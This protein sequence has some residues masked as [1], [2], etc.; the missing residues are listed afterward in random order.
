M[1]HQDDSGISPSDSSSQYIILTTRIGLY[2]ISHQSLMAAYNAELMTSYTYKDSQGS[3]GL[4]TYWNPQNFV[5][6]DPIAQ[7]VQCRSN[8]CNACTSTKNNP[9][10]QVSFAGTTDIGGEIVPLCTQR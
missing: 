5:N 3:T 6:V 2:R 7:N 8:Q 9:Q 4:V 1:E 10:N